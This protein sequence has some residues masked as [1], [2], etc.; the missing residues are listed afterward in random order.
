[1]RELPKRGW[2]V[3]VS[4]APL[5]GPVT[6]PLDFLTYGNRVWIICSG[7]Q[8]PRSSTTNPDVARALRDQ[9]AVAGV[10]FFFLQMGAGQVIPRDLRIRQFPAGQRMRRRGLL[11]SSRRQPI[12]IPV[13]TLPDERKADDERKGGCEWDADYSDIELPPR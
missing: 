12:P 3:F 6:L 9:C 10:P 7:E 2:I 5:V 8:D 4:V 13:D 11:I 1:M